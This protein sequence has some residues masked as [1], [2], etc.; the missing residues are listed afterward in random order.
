M[1]TP[2]RITSGKSDI[3]FVLAEASLYRTGFSYGIKRME[4]P[5]FVA[6]RAKVR[7]ILRLA[8]HQSARDKTGCRLSPS[9]RRAQAPQLRV[10][11]R[12]LSG[13]RLHRRTRPN[14]DRSSRRATP[15]RAFAHFSFMLLFLA[16]VSKTVSRQRTCPAWISR[17]GLAAYRRLPLH[18]YTQ[19]SLPSAGIW[20][21]LGLPG[22]NRNAESARPGKPNQSHC[23]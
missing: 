1:F 3:P 2:R 23:P 17:V 16:V 8:V 19:T 20:R 15:P 7:R 9:S 22:Q 5:S 13:C 14:I 10:L 21:W 18:P 12:T 11:R 6:K 4:A